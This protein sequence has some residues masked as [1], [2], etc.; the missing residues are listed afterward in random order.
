MGVD[1]VVEPLGGPAVRPRSLDRAGRGA[2]GAGP[3]R[4]RG[5]R[6]W[7]DAVVV[8]VYIVAAGA[9]ATVAAVMVARVPDNRIGWIL[10][11]IAVWMVVTFL[12][13]MVLYH[14]HSPGD[15]QTALAN[16]LGTWTFV[17]AVPTS[18][19]LMIFPS[20]KLPSP[21]WRLLPWLAVIGTAGWVVLEATSEKLGAEE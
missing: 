10:G 7:V 14:L 18:L 16:W 13:I 6:R 4:R 21:R 19:V 20:G 9:L 15:T 17:I 12:L 2:R 11:A 1:H 5:L 8:V 3:D